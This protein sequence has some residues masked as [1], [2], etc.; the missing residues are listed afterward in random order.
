V[1]PVDASP[2]DASPCAS[3]AAM[4]SIATPSVRTGCAP[5]NCTGYA[6]CTVGR[7]SLVVYMC[8]RGTADYYCMM[9]LPTG[10]S[11]GDN[12]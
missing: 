10:K 7:F 2:V 4:L 11:F 12:A 5:G 1:S 9:I 3:P 8:R 6:A